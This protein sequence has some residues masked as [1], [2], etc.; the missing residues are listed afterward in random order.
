[1]NP[2]LQL[3]LSILSNL[4]RARA[5]VLELLNANQDRAIEDSLNLIDVAIKDL[6]TSKTVKDLI[7]R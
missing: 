7:G 4:S 6:N 1:M 2:D 5:H 3:Y